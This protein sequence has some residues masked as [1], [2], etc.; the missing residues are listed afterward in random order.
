MRIYGRNPV[1]EAAREGRVRKVYLARGVEPKLVRQVERLGVPI[2]WTSRIELAQMVGTTRHQGIV[3]EV[4]RF[5]AADLEA[6]FALAE[7]RRA[8]LLLVL[9][10]GVT[11][12][13]NFGAIIRSAEAL[14]AHGVMAESRRSAPISPVVVKASAG[15][16][17]RLPIIRVTNLPREIEALKSRGVWV[18]G[19]AGE[20][21]T[22]IAEAE[23]RGPSALVVGSEGKGLRRLVRERCDALFSIPLFGKTPSLNVAVALGIA[24]YQAA[25]S[26]DRAG[27]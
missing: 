15:A 14:G 9:V 23:F 5:E 20:A 11:D 21:K 10:D 24:L 12:P 27:V 22:P 16:A 8:P 2:V 26:R 18:Y 17:L 19:L 4:D 13:R 6:A 3:A 7:S 1:L 25:L